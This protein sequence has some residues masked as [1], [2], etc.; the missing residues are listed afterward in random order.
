MVTARDAGSIKDM[1]QGRDNLTLELFLKNIAPTSFSLEVGGDQS[2]GCQ[3]E[4][5]VRELEKLLS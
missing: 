2:K 3:S 5:L 4:V 1:K